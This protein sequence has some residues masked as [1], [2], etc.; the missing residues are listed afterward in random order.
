MAK[1]HNRANGDLFEKAMVVYHNLSIGCDTYFEPST[2]ETVVYETDADI[3]TDAGFEARY[4]ELVTEAMSATNAVYGTVDAGLGDILD[5]A[6]SAASDPVLANGEV[7]T[8]CGRHTMSGTGDIDMGD[9]RTTEAK[10]V[11]SGTGTYHQTSANYLSACLG[12]V[13][14]TGKDSYLDSAGYYDALSEILSAHGLPAPKV[15]ASSPVSRP[16]ASMISHKYPEVAEEIKQVEAS[17][18]Y[19]YISYV[20]EQLAGD[21]GLFTKFCDDMLNK[22]KVR[23]ATAEPHVSDYLVVANKRNKQVSVYDLPSLIE[24]AKNDAG[25]YEYNVSMYDEETGTY[26]ESDISS[27]DLGIMRATLSWK[28]HVG[29]NNPAIYIFLTI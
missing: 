27:F 14:Y 7:W 29:L 26:D 2:G 5:L 15:N 16:T 18:R 10:F 12:L 3:S 17:Y 11:G 24:E 19:G 1:E 28:N 22:L 4:K 25:E 8:Q 20:R 9:G 6:A 23:D 21:A 13:P